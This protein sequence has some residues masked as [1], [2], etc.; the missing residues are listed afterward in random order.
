M[1]TNGRANTVNDVGLSGRLCGQYVGRPYPAAMILDRS[2]RLTQWNEYTILF[3]HSRLLASEKMLVVLRD[4]R[5]L[6]G[7][8]RSYDQFGEIRLR[9]TPCSVL[10]SHHLD[11]SVSLVS[12]FLPFHHRRHTTAMLSHF[13]Q[14][15]ISCSKILLSGYTTLA[16]TVTSLVVSS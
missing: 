6:I 8:L 15:Q 13:P 2:K 14:Q 4:G 9:K 12:I 11:L 3:L 7:V 5:K 16:R 10:V 1:A